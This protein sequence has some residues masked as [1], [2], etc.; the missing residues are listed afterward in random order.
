MK[1]QL[2]KVSSGP[3]HS[4]SVRKDYTP[5]FNN[6]W[7]YH[8][9]VEL[10]HFKKGA[11]TQFIGDSIKH[12]KNGD[13]ILVGKQ[14]PHYWRFDDSHFKDDS[15]TSVDVTVV[16]FCEDFWGEGF[17]QLK[18]N[19]GIRSV[20][21]NARRGIEITGN[22]KVKVSALLEKMLIAEGPERIILL[23]EALMEISLCDCPNLLSS[24]VFQHK[25]DSV[26]NDRINAIYEYSLANFKNKIPLEEIASV[27]N[28]SP[29]AFCRYFKSQ[30]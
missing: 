15:K 5:H 16:H 25:P 17:L 10:I 30:T 3:A 28:I 22:A 8:N 20:L 7:H 27:A 29:S 23:M 6:R 14:L 18:E 1:P 13:V 26:Y 4:F 24:D 12:F 2:L 21:E 19:E 11:G 9:E